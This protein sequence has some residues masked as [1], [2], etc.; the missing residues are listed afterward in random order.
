MDWYITRSF[1]I[2]VKFY[3]NRM[4]R[5]FTKIPVFGK[6]KHFSSFIIK[7]KISR[8]LISTIALTSSIFFSFHFLVFTFS[9]NKYTTAFCETKEESRYEEQPIYRILVT[10]GENGGK[11]SAIS[12]IANRLMNMGFQVFIVPDSNTILRNGNGQFTQNMTPEQNVKFYGSQIEIQMALEDSFYDIAKSSGKKSVIIMQKGT[13]DIS[14]YMPPGIWEV[15]LDDY[16]LSL[17]HLRDKRY[18]GVFHMVTTAIGSPESFLK[19]GSHLTIEQATSL[20]FKIINACKNFI[21]TFKGLD[22]H[23]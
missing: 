14:A 9:Y 3:A 19:K 21:L 1:I 13:L 10:G 11:S 15:L 23:I 12:A 18:D 5:K 16:G 8:V 20:D 7:N 4:F 17:I 6:M 22:T 2:R